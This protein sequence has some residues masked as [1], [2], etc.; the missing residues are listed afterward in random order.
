MAFR[1]L[2]E[3]PVTGKRVFIRADLNVPIRDGHITDA[4]RI[5]AALQAIKWVIA[6]GGRPIVASH[7]GRPKGKRVPELSLRPIGEYLAEGAIAPIVM[8]RR[9]RHKFVHSP[10]DPDQLYDLTADPDE[11]VNLSSRADCG[12]SAPGR[13]GPPSRCAAPWRAR[14]CRCSR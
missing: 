10:A 12:P 2:E 4:T 8:I 6:N 5:D 9:G 14:H 11:R 3:V 1:T 7:L 13:G